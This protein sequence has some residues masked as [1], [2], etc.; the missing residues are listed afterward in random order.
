M[1]PPRVAE[2]LIE[3]LHTENIHSVIIAEMISTAQGRISAD[4]AIKVDQIVEKYW[5]QHPKLPPDLTA[6]LGRWKMK[7][8]LMSQREAKRIVSDDSDWYARAELVNALDSRTIPQPDLNSVLLSRI[9]D[10]VSDVAIAAAI[11][12][13]LQETTV[14]AETPMQSSASPVLSAFGMLDGKYR[15]A[16]GIKYA[17]ERLLNQKPPGVNWKK[18]FGNTFRRAEIQAI[19]W[20]GYL[21]DATAWVNSM[22]VFCDWLLDAL[23]RNDPS[24]GKYSLGNIGSNLVVGSRL[25][26]R[27]PRTFAFV[28]SIHDKR[29]ESDLSHAKKRIGKTYLKPTSFIRFTY[30]KTA[31]RLAEASL[32]EISQ[33]WPE[34][35]LKKTKR[36]KKSIK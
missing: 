2:N 31:K 24:I 36:K 33:S 4:Q 13:G 8:D 32:K 26:K 6:V 10:S 35:V 29:S 5:M 9:N 1:L 30:F 3:K 22:H 23:F 20:S 17:F 12:L 27:Y 11:H 19:R 14:N 34:K 28:S 7:R 16:C 15:K 21:G 18:F 25:E